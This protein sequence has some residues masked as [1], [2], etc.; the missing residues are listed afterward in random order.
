MYYDASALPCQGPVQMDF[1]RRNLLHSLHLAA[2]TLPVIL[3]DDITD[4]I[5]TQCRL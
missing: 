2:P 5:W 4:R 3:G 1:G